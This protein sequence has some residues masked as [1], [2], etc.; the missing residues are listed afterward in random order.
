MQAAQAGGTQAALG[1]VDDALEG[2]V[3]V[4]LDD[5]PQVGDGVADLLALV[6]AGAAD[7][8]VGDAD[9]DQALFELAGLEAGA[10]QH[11]HPAQR[12]VVAAQRLD[13]LAD[14]PRLVLAVPD[15]AHLHLL[16]F[17]LGGPQR[18][19][20]PAAVVGDQAG[21]G[22]EDMRGRAVVALQADDP[23]AGEVALEAQDVADLGAAPRVDRLVVV[24]DAAQVVM[25][26][27]QRPQPQVLGD[28]G[29]LV[30]VDQNVAELALVLAGDLR[31]LAEQGQDVQ[32]QVAEV[33]GVERAQ[34]LLV[35]GVEA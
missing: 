8:P 35:F 17:A 27:R 7:D 19:A 2:E 34:P 13:L 12:V 24:A 4:G 5:D 28:V 29:V 22:G 31:M 20:E 3:V 15:A 18:L 6:E 26:L 32:Q 21:G 9:G 16:A 30:L 25:A 14:D 33:G 10:D 11:R 1:N 23:G